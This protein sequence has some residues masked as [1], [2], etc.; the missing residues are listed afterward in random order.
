MYTPLRA[1]SLCDGVGPT[2]NFFIFQTQ[3]NVAYE[4]LTRSSSRLLTFLNNFTTLSLASEVA[5]K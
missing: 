2:R 1:S 5:T 4:T 3:I